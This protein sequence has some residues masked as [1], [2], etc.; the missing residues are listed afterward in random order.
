MH[1]PD[2]FTDRLSDYLDGELS[3]AERR[4]LDAHLVSCESCRSVL[5]DL[6][7]VVADARM[8]HDRAPDADLW[9]G[10]AS[11]LEPRDSRRRVLDWLREAA[12]HRISFTLPQLAAAALALA[13]LSGG[14]V[15]LARS[16]NPRA[17]FPP[18]SADATSSGAVQ[19][20]NFADAEFDRAIAD[21]ER[22]L[23]ED[24]GAL[25]PATIGVVEAN[26]RTIDQAIAE[27]RRALAV[28][29]GNTY[30]N[31]HLARARQR[32]LALLRRVTGLA[33]IGS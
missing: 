29:P 26:L 24:R 8:V 32:K 11:R 14:L 33:S 28:D 4:S 6:R 9:T 15:W 3:A 17:D 12:R 18:L 22:I 20:A 21:L 16:G 31:S 7:A 13:V 1:T 5:D 25:D 19:P 27:S 23:S 2:R 30:L 10:I